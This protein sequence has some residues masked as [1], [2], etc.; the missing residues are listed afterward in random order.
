MQRKIWANESI[1]PFI[2]YL[3]ISNYVLFN[4]VTQQLVLNKLQ[5][6]KY[7]HAMHAEIV[8]T[9]QRF[10]VTYFRRCPL[11]LRRR[12]TCR[13][14]SARFF[15]RGIQTRRLLRLRWLVACHVRKLARFDRAGHIRFLLGLGR[16]RSFDGGH[17][18]RGDG[19]AREIGY[20]VWGRVGDDSRGEGGRGE[21]NCAQVGKTRTHVGR[22]FGASTE[23]TLQMLWNQSENQ[24]NPKKDKSTLPVL[25]QLALRILNVLLS[26]Q[27]RVSEWSSKQILAF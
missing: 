25:S 12:N 24:L 20:T 17:G 3:R 9:I 27:N 1:R 13:G 11:A 15:L 4:I 16:L 14:T 19:S 26:K 6:T 7:T 8:S 10:L 21:E 5:N 23:K 18:T 2:L 22:R